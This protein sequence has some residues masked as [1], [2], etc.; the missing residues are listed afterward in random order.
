MA[1]HASKGHPLR[2][3]GPSSKP[4]QGP[5]TLRAKVAAARAM[6]AI[7]ERLGEPT[8]PAVLELSRHE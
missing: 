4:V 3:L 7:N 2:S 8:E 5:P 1:I 6:V